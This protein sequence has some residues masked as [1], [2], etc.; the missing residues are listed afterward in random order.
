MS[1]ADEP[2]CDDFLADWY[3][4][5]KKSLVNYAV[6]KMWELIFRYI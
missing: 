6:C 5:T 2:N 4:A 1:A 3:Q